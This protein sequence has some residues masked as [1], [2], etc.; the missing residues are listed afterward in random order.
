MALKLMIS[1]SR[2]S[3][4]HQYITML[5]VPGTTKEDENDMLVCLSI[6]Q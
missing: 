3:A 2:L 6:H 1:R 4:S 5:Q